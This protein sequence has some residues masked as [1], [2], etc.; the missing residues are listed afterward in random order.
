VR[1]GGVDRSR[2][3]VDAQVVT[4]HGASGP[5]AGELCMTT[6]RTDATADG[7]LFR[8]ARQRFRRAGGDGVITLQ[9]RRR[10]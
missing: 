5:V 8:C 10:T 2:R 1:I 6:G 4:R 3:S 7:N 9:R